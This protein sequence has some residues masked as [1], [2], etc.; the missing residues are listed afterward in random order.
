M[1]MKEERK[2]YL[3]NYAKEH[4]KRIPLDVSHEMYD[5]IKAH[6]DRAGMPVNRYLKTAAEEKMAC[7]DEGQGGEA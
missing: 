7:E 3:L 1:P 5:N 6:A 4:V 2:N